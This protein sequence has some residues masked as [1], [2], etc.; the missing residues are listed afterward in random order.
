MEEEEKNQKVHK[1]NPLIMLSVFLQYRHY[2]ISDNG[3]Q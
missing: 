3:E 2:L 1:L